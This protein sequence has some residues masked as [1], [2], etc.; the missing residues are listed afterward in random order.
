VLGQDGYGARAFEWQAVRQHVKA[1]YTQRV[2]IASPIQWLAVRLLRTHEVRRARHLSDSAVATVLRDP[3][4]AEVRH[5]RAGDFSQ[6]ARR[7][8]G[9]KWPAG[10][11]SLRDGLALHIGHG[12]E[13]KVFH[14]VH[15]VD[16]HD[17]GVP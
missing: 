9:R 7:L 12:E 17:V 2:E 5:Q 1:D 3:C 4:D 10:R 11:H 15:D 16:R 13:D 6:D 14:F 8:F